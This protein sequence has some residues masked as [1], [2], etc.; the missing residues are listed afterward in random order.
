M[1]QSKYL[2][3]DWVTSLFLTCYSFAVG[4]FGTNVICH[5]SLS[6]TDV[7]WLNGKSSRSVMVPSDRVLVTSY[8]LSIVPIVCYHVSICSGLAAVFN[9]RFQAISGRISERER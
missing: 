8:W 4:I 1:V 7:L 3:C 9:G 6:V 5:L 2:L